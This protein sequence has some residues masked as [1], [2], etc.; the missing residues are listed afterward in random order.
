MEVIEEYKG[1]E[2]R[3]VAIFLFTLA[4]SHSSEVKINL[5]AKKVMDIEVPSKNILPHCTIPGDPAKRN[6]WLGIYVF[7][8]KRVEWLGERRQRLPQECEKYKMELVQLLKKSKRARVIGVES[9]DYLE[10]D[11]LA[12]VMKDP[13]IKAIDGNWVFSRVLT[14]KGC[15]GWQKGCEEPRLVE[16]DIYTNIYQ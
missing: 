2:M 15:F 16:K 11:N 14:D 4:C 7:Y 5:Y 12:V 8:N 6:S 3:L 1:L 9:S 13:S 10:D